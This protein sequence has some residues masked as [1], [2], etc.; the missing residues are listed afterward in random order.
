MAR[1]SVLQ[2]YRNCS[3]LFGITQDTPNKVNTNNQISHATEQWRRRFSLI[4]PLTS[5]SF[6]HKA[7]KPIQN[8]ETKIV[9]PRLQTLFQHLVYKMCPTPIVSSLCMHQYLDGLSPFFA[10]LSFRPEA[11]DPR[12]LN[13]L[14]PYFST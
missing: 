9:I 13:A 12:I 14:P 11:G 2:N 4:K 6:A 1:K 8:T 10:P 7:N 3:R 5:K